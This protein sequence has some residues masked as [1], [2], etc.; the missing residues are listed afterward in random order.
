MIKKPMQGRFLAHKKNRL[1]S[2]STHQC[3]NN[4]FRNIPLQTCGNICGVIATTL[5]AICSLDQVLW[6]HGFLNQKVPLPEPIAWIL[7]PTAHADYLRHV[8][9]HWLMARHVDLKMLGRTNSPH[10]EVIKQL[11]STT[12]DDTSESYQPAYE[13]ARIAADDDKIPVSSPTHS[14][15]IN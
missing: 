2:C 10:F 12:S 5:G 15:C 8:I 11:P 9:I 6:R 13:G 14:N 7:T 1:S 4:C 3:S